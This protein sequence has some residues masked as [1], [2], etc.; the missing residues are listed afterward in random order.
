MVHTY[1]RRY[2]LS[3]AYGI[4]ERASNDTSVMSINSCAAPAPAHRSI[5]D[6]RVPPAVAAAVAFSLSLSV[7]AASLLL[8]LP[9][10]GV[11]R[12]L[13]YCVRI[14]PRILTTDPRR[15]PQADA[16]SDPLSVGD[17]LSDPSLHILHLQSAVR[18][19]LV[20][21]TQPCIPP[22]SLN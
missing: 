17:S 5:C 10:H 1:S 14:S 2:S 11:V 3:A 18:P 4:T 15:R 19:A 7:P 8:L 9:L 16:V 12:I 6:A 13:P 22:G 21:S 20:R